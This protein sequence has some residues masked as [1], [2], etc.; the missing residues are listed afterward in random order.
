M[1][2]GPIYQEDT[3]IV[4]IY[5]ANIEATKYIKL[6]LTIK[7]RNGQQCDNSRRIYSHTLNN[8]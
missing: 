5:T 2:K 4:N 3:E 1:T 7:G 6:I 8:G